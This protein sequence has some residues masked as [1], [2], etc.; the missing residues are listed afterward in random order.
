MLAKYFARNFYQHPMCPRIK[1]S[2]ILLF[3]LLSLCFFSF[4]YLVP[5]TTAQSSE[6]FQFTG[7]VVAL[8]AD[9]TKVPLANVNVILQ[10]LQGDH[11]ITYQATTGASGYF[12][13][14]TQGTSGCM[15]HP[16]GEYFF[17]NPFVYYS[18]YTQYNYPE[19][20]ICPKCCSTPLGS[21]D[22]GD[23]VMIRNAITGIVT[24]AT[25]E[26]VSNVTVTSESS[27]GFSAQKKAGANSQNFLSSRTA[28]TDSNGRYVFS[29]LDPTLTHTVTPSTTS[30]T[31][32][33]PTSQSF[34]DVSSLVF[35]NFSIK[36]PIGFKS[37]DK[38]FAPSV[39]RLLFSYNINTETNN[40][41]YAKFEVFRSA[42]LISPIYKDET[43]PRTGSDVQYSQNGT[44]GWNGIIN[45]GTDAGKYIEPKDGPFTIRLSVANQA[46]YSDARKDEK[47]I[48]VEIESISLTPSNTQ[49]VYK[50][51]RTAT[52]IDK[53][54]EAT[55]KLKNKDGDG[56]V[57][58]IP[59]KIN[60]SF[61]DPDDTSS[62]S[63]VIDTNGS[64][65]ND[66]ALTSENGKREDIVAGTYPGVMWKTISG[67]PATIN[68]GAQTAVAITLT[69]GA[70]KG[71]AKLKFS[72][73]RV[74][75]DNYILVAKYLNND[76]TT[77][78]EKKSGT[79]TVWK[80]LNFNSV[81][82]MSGGQAID[83]ITTTLNID[84]QYDRVFSGDGYTEYS[85]GSVTN[86]QSGNQSPE[87]I[88]DLLPPQA[89]ELP[90]AGD[91]QQTINGKAQQWYN[92]NQNHINSKLVAYTSLIN[93]PATSLIGAKYLHPKL[94]GNTNTANPIDPATGSPF[95]YY[96]PATR[97]T[98]PYGQVDPDTEWGDEQG[99]EIL[100]R[101]FV[102]LNIASQAKAIVVARHEIGH[103]SD[104]VQF[105]LNDPP[106]TN[107]HAASGLMHPDAQNYS[108]PKFSPRSI[109]RLRGV[110]R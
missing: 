91:T 56:V 32:F 22:F 109:L 78:V 16:D 92:R 80:R 8:Q 47:T 21:H 31:T 89:S 67:F 70:D 29:E 15:L 99:A 64:A 3:L 6:Y 79:W 104:H 90:T 58:A 69:S 96:P 62:H 98:T 45:Q 41:G 101:S 53:T 40:Y 17:Y 10:V 100:D 52:E 25:D 94:D 43:I 7:R 63:S 48:N 18:N 60:W 1:S 107:D 19:A 110:P 87:F 46:D 13:F 34:S 42:N 23:V 85:R 36:K 26:P 73:S 5:Q 65:G 95:D 81:Y 97:I 76:G 71:K 2:S 39:E 11:T 86:L 59:L 74:A 27:S 84:P 37:Y 77:L 44:L 102:F 88:A 49:K 108:A 106:G 33:S 61:E 30:G 14:N 66:N 93:A 50:P 54:I 82:K 105:D 68:T 75:G 28:Q 55:V 83:V 57:T 35:A 12:Q 4:L 38:R 9:S 103:A 20:R 72:A 24:D 51:N